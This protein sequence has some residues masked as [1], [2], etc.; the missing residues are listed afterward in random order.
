MMLRTILVLILFA[1]VMA[2]ASVGQAADALRVLNLQRSYFNLH[3]LLPDP[4]LQAAAE[5]AAAERASRGITGH[6]N[7]R[8]GNPVAGRWEGTGHDSRSDM[9]GI[10]FHSCYQKHKSAQYAGVAYVVT[11]HGTYYQL[12]LR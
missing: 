12:N 8:G 7:G 3:P 11:R 1:G 2:S 9:W 6:L 4:Q 10:R 5:R